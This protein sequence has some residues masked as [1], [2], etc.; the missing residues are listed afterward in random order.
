MPVGAL[1]TSTSMHSDL[2][3]TDVCPVFAYADL[4]CRATR[5]HAVT[6]THHVHKVLLTCMCNRTRQHAVSTV[7]HANQ[8]QLVQMRTRSS[9]KSLLGCSPDGIQARPVP[10]AGPAICVHERASIGVLAVT[11]CAAGESIQSGGEG[12]LLGGRVGVEEGVALEG[13]ELV[14]T[15][16]L[17]QGLQ[18][19]EEQLLT[20][21]M[22]AP[23]RSC[24]KACTERRRI[25]LF[26]SI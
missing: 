6:M 21:G 17:H 1:K 23:H 14:L 20:L 5:N 26:F 4:K 18:Q 15:L 22:P 8:L 16:G 25:P 19:E 11:V 10:H 7:E 2:D 24:T 13:V 12:G 3:Q 9:S